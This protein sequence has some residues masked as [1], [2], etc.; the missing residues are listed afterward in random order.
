MTDRE[1]SGFVQNLF[2]FLVPQLLSLL[3]ALSIS[4]PRSALFTAELQSRLLLDLLS[5]GLQMLL[6]VVYLVVAP[7]R[8]LR[9]ALIRGFCHRFDLQSFQPGS[10]RFSLSAAQAPD[11]GG[12]TRGYKGVS[13]LS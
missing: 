12:E 13:M 9:F 6:L 8:R 1:T 4:S 11:A 7:I 5:T 3:R 2:Q 10:G